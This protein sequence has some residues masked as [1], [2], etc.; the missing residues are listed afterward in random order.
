MN[1]TEAFRRPISRSPVVDRSAM[2]MSFGVH[3]GV[4][5]LIILAGLLMNSGPT[6]VIMG[7]GSMVSVEMVVFDPLSDSGSPQH[8]STEIEQV[9]VEETVQ[10][11]ELIQELMESRV[12]EPAEVEP[13]EIEPVE[14]QPAEIQPAEVQ[15]AEVQP[16]EVQPAEVQP[17]EV[18][19]A[20]QFVT[21]GS[22]GEAGA[23][24]PGPASYEGRVFAAIRRNF[25]TSTDPPN[26]YRIHFTVN[27]DGTYRYEVVRQSGSSAFDRAVEHA[28]ETANIPP[29]P[30]GR[31]NPVRLSI[32]FLGPE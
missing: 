13:V 10:I 31:T 20:G 28:L 30:P 2:V 5:V 19:P 12:V 4:L 16:A 23:G 11:P 26:T 14:I 18:Q 25:V 32:E 6:P 21:V 24:A 22:S 1:S 7:G 17:A 27:T 3:T 8:V 15:P 9:Q 29:M